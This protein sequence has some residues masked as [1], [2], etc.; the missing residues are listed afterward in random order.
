MDTEITL[1]SG[2]DQAVIIKALI[3]FR[4]LAVSF[5]LGAVIVFQ[6]K[7]G[8]LLYP[9]PISLLIAAT[10][11]LSILYLTLI[12]RVRR[13]AP[14]LYFQLTTD[15]IIET[16][17][18]YYTGGVDSPFTFLYM[19]T[20]VASVIIMQANSSYILA[21]VASI[22]YGLLVNLEFYGAISPRPLL[23]TAVDQV[24]SQ[25]YVFFTVLVHIA[26]FYL[27]AFLS[28]FL[29]R[30]LSR[31]LL[32]LMVKSSDLTYL[33][34]FHQNVVA[35]MGSG[36]M[37]LDLGRTIV[38]A[39]QAAE[40]ILERRLEDFLRR[41]LED[42]FPSLLGLAPLSPAMETKRTEC[43][44]DMGGRKKLLAVTVSPFRNSA[45]D[46]LGMILIFQDITHFK[47]ME[48]AMAKSERMAAVGRMAAGLAHE[49]RNPLGSISGSIQMLRTMLTAEMPSPHDRLMAII[50]RETDRLNGI[51]SRFLSYANPTTKKE[52][53]V[54]LASLIS[55]SVLLF[56]NDARYASITTT[57]D[58]DPRIRCECDAEALKQVF[59]NLLLNSA[60][61]MPNGGTI[62]IAM[63]PVP[64]G[65]SAAQE[66]RI[67]ISDTGCGIP[68]DAAGKIFEPFFTTKENGTGLGLPLVAKIIES[69]NGLIT[70]QSKIDEGATFT[71]RLP[72]APLRMD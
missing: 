33:Q 20:I 41:R 49:I 11:L 5:F 58:L 6:V 28:D 27:V 36:F 50:L 61:A 4:M 70:V 44:Y 29:A 45:G 15:L 12:G 1:P 19:L 34:A 64:S 37:A 63:K 2:R 25:A 24:P 17:I 67:D 71:L 10:Y 22:L 13:F 65:A 3:I 55:D 14:F 16:G 7:F 40:Q 30:R 9:L 52:P 69:H 32:A 21:S 47:E 18:I 39:N 54:N 56:S 57:L 31:T 53:D 62:A 59:W 60:Q 51:I 8:A 68:D 35:N 38:S 42:A 46:V 48:E 26:A 23:M 66:C 72:I 43:V